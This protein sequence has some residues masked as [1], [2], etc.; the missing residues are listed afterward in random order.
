MTYGF[1]VDKY[2]MLARI[3]F[4]LLTLSAGPARAVGV[5]DVIGRCSLLI[6]KSGIAEGVPIEVFHADY[7]KAGFSPQSGGQGEAGLY[8]S[9]YDPSKSVFMKSFTGE[10]P[11]KDLKKEIQFLQANQDLEGIPKLY[12]WIKEP[13]SII[14]EDVGGV[15]V[16]ELINASTDKTSLRSMLYSL[17]EGAK[18]L[19]S[20]HARGYVHGDVKP[21]NIVMGTSGDVFVVDF[22]GH[23]KV[24][25]RIPLD[26]L[27]TERYRAPE[28]MYLKKV[29]VQTDVY[30][31]GK[32]LYDIVLSDLELFRQGKET[33]FTDQQRNALSDLVVNA[34]RADPNLRPSMKEFRESLSRFMENLD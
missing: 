20:L 34:T 7:A 10:N 27:S 6:S 4:L 17:S 31:M 3:L 30:A 25:D 12:G 18:I 28:Q 29:T 14:L 11:Y 19:E 16:R 33:A 26:F 5:L 21:N 22:S 1:G 23:L 24:G 8:Q 15:D 32:S 13:P 2:P 9:K